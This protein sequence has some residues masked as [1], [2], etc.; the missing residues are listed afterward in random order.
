[1]AAL[2]LGTA[3]IQKIANAAKLKRSS[4]YAYIDELLEAG[5]LEK[6]PIGKR[7][8]YRATEPERIQQKMKERLNAFENVMGDLTALRNH[9]TAKPRVR[10]LEGREGIREIYNEMLDAPF[11][12]A[13]S[14]L[15]DIE[16]LFPEE[17]VKISTTMKERG[18]RMRELMPNKDEAR[19][20]ARRFGATAGS[21]YEARMIEGEVFNDNLIYG[22]VNAILRIHEMDLFVVRIEDASMAT[23]MRTLFDA[24]WKSAKPY[25]PRRNNG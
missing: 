10:I 2:S 6:V 24:A 25:F 16:R 5:L 22:D 7:L 9:A 4:V 13:Y 3:S 21:M 8:Y 12:R 1:M 15:P 23:S 19:R 14:Y 20:T 11:I 17:V 18:I